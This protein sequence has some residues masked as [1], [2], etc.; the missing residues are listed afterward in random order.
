M[1]VRAA[2]SGDVGT[3]L[4]FVRELAEY[5]REPDA[6]KADDAMMTDALFGERPAAEALIAE[7]A[8][9][10]VGFALFFHNFSTWEGRRG[11]Y[12]EDLYVTPAVRGSGAGKALLKACARIA[13]ERGCA[14]FEWAVLDWNQP[15][16]DFYRAMGA[17]GM[18]EW[19]VQRVSGDAL[20]RLAAGG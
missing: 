3:I 20:A 1:N 9:E 11:L 19:T 15:A 13:L 7:V 4:R 5:E 17:V 16:I 10:P 18:D 8:G 6:V 12:L 14:R 2:V